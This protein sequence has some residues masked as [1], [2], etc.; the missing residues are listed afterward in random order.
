VTRC[1]TAVR[2]RANRMVKTGKTRKQELEQDR[3]TGKNAGRLDETKR[4]DNRQT[5]HRYKYTV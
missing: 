5:E 3:H 2:V 1:R 4:T